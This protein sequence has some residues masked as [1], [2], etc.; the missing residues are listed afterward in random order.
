[1]YL[2]YNWLQE[3]VKIPK[4]ISP[5]QLGEK[6]TLHTVEIE[7]VEKQADRF[8]NIVVGKIKEVKAHPNADKLQLAR[9]DVGEQELDIVCGAPNIEKG[10]LVP[11]ALVGAVLENGLEIKEAEVRGEI[12]R[13]ML[14]AEDELGLGEDHSGI[15]ILDKKAKVG[16]NLAQYFGFDDILFEVDNKSL[17]NRPDLMG[18]LGM[19]REVAAFLDCKKSS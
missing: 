15:M 16:R 5:E 10:Q 7:G 11:V 2:S 9:V 18:H 17:T 13:G 12:S 8:A 14:C 3:L 4:N 1:M 6:L 19:A